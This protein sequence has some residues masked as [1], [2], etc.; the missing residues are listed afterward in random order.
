[1]T[2]T[3]HKPVA[4]RH[5]VEFD[6][7]RGIAALAVL[8]DHTLLVFHWPMSLPWVNW[9]GIN[10]LFNGVGAVTMFFVLSGFVLSWPFVAGATRTLTTKVVAAFYIRRV[11]RI[12]LPWL[13]IFVVSLLV[14]EFLFEPPETIPPQTIWLAGFWRSETT[15]QGIL[16]QC[17]YML[18]DASQQ[19]LPQ[20][21]SLG[22]E[23]KASAVMPLMILAVLRSSWA[24]ALWGAVMLGALPHGHYYAPF[25]VGVLLAR[26]CNLMVV[27]FQG[28]QPWARAALVLASIGLFQS[29]IFFAGSVEGNMIFEKG[30]WIGTS[31]GAGLLMVASIGCP[32]ISRFLHRPAARILGAISFSVYLVHFIVLVWLVPIFVN[33]LNRVGVVDGYAILVFTFAASSIAT[34]LLAWCSHRWIELPSIAFGRR[35][36]ALILEPGIAAARA[37]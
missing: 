12:W 11:T 26:H 21:W 30:I 16:L 17:A 24:L 5:L 1:M 2:S 32:A 3:W 34:L 4:P 27:W 31:V 19:M 35:L 28:V 13:C 8:L 14:K 18:H 25:F 23:M 33:A 20:D 6:S 22:V 9:P 15:V 29:R 36:S 10:I 37:R 7:L